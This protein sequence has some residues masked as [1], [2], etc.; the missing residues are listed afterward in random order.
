MGRHENFA[1]TAA[2]QKKIVGMTAWFIVAVCFCLAT[3][4]AGDTN[5][6]I[7]VTADRWQA[8]VGDQN[9]H[10]VVFFYSPW[11]GFCKR[12]G[13]TFAALAAAHK[14]QKEFVFARINGYANMD[15]ARQHG[16]TK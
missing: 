10:A 3:G 16:I 7:E 6:V 1:A 12:F 8:V 13:P 4:L 14:Q 5:A 9:R 15:L 11:S 2:A